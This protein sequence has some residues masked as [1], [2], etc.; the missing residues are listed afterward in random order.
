MPTTYGLPASTPAERDFW[1]KLETNHNDVGN[2]NELKRN[3]IFI[4]DL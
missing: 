2:V 4:D 3:G 1:S